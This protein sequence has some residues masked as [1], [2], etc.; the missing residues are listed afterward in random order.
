MVN[1]KRECGLTK[2]TSGQFDRALINLQKN[3]FITMCGR[4][5]KLS[6]KGESYDWNIKVCI[7]AEI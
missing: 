5:K 1:L 3:L 4:R 7:Y 2:E 6:R